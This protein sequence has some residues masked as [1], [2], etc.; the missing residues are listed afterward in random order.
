MQFPETGDAGLYV[1]TLTK[2]GFYDI[3]IR[4]F[5]VGKSRKGILPTDLFIAETVG[6]GCFRK[7]P[8]RL[9]VPCRGN[10]TFGAHDTGG[11]KREDIRKQKATGVSDAPR[12]GSLCTARAG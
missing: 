10:R 7:C 9:G 12:K 8:A 3:I 6:D 11:R 2:A 4:K 5:Y 1:L